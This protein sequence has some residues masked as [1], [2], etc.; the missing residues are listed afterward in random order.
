MELDSSPLEYRKVDLLLTKYGRRDGVSLPWLGLERKC[1]FFHYSL[2]LSGTFALGKP[3]AICT[4]S[5]EAPRRETR[6]NCQQPFECAVLEADSPDQQR[7]LQMTAALF[8]FCP[9]PEPPLYTSLEFW[10]HRNYEIINVCCFKLLTLRVIINT[11]EKRKEGREEKEG[12]KSNQKKM[13]LIKHSY[14]AQ[15]KNV[16]RITK[17]HR[18][19]TS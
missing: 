13:L 1:D 16:Q 2:S 12:R 11:V 10:T 14:T 8:D 4:D 17:N 15:P 6:T 18:S 9:E 5:Q 7:S 19:L 3:A